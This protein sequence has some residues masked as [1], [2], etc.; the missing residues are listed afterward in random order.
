MSA[1]VNNTLSSVFNYM[2]KKEYIACAQNFISKSLR[3]NSFDIKIC[4]L[5][6]VSSICVQL[7]CSE[8]FEIHEI[9]TYY[10]QFARFC[11][12]KNSQGSLFFCLHCSKIDISVLTGDPQFKL[13]V[14]HIG[15]WYNF[16]AFV[17]L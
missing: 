9:K 2:I 12:C 7:K 1:Y 13:S 14:T 11:F 17:T 3:T 5:F 10:L 15:S 4:I 8:C 16:G 6:P